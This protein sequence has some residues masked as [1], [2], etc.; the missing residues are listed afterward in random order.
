M[1]VAAVV[2]FGRPAGEAGVIREGVWRRVR[3]EWERAGCDL[4]VA[5]DPA[6]AARGQFSVS[7]AINNAVRLALPD[8]DRFVCFGADMAPCTSTVTCADAELDTQPLTLLFD[9]GSSVGE[10]AT[11]G[12]VVAGH[13]GS[14]PELEL[15]A[16]PCVGS[17]AFTRETFDRVG[18]FDERYEGW[19]YEDVDFWY[20]LQRDVRALRRRRTPARRWSSSGTRRCTTTCR[21]TTRTSGCSPRPGA[22][23]LPGEAGSCHRPRL[24]HER[25]VGGIQLRRADVR[26]PPLPDHDDHADRGDQFEQ[27]RRGRVGLLDG[28]AERVDVEHHQRQRYL[29][30][31]HEGWPWK[32]GGYTGLQKQIPCARRRAGERCSTSTHI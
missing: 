2:P 6:F 11:K 13:R 22:D 17:I 31:L 16:S 32:L 15:F 12:W 19:A 23:W 30:V 14:Y 10:A 26:L 21:W 3:T 5:A 20:R 25:G 24:A 27:R 18:G 8:C 29:C 4:I 9:H 28:A 7:R 1:G